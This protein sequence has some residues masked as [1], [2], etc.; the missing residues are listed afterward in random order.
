LIA[1]SGGHLSITRGV[2]GTG[3]I[4]VAPG[5]RLSVE[6]GLSGR[7]VT[8]SA[9]GV[10]ELCSGELRVNTWNGDFRPWTWGIDSGLYCFADAAIKVGTSG[11]TTIHGN[12]RLDDG[13]TVG[14]GIRGSGPIAA[15]QI[16]VSGGLAI[17]G[18]ALQLDVTQAQCP[19]ATRYFNII[20]VGG[21]LV[22]RFTD[23]DEGAVVGQLCGQDLH[24]SYRGGDGN[25]V[26]VATIGSSPPPDGLCEL[27]LP[28]W[29]GWRATLPGN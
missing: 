15:D 9:G 25:D 8:I 11:S 16:R 13:W 6:W 19:S 17:A 21:D 5:A 7:T 3:A 22:G 27:C 26:V 20:E 4:E 12:A 28:S 23:A 29:G 2:S 18:A 10:F 24:I 1:A 14:I